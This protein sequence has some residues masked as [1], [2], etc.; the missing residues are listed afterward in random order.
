MEWYPILRFLHIA[1]A[2]VF[3][4]GLF[5]RQI[6]RAVA[7]KS[8]DVR[9]FAALSRGASRIE[10]LM[11]RP[12]SLA[13]ILF[14]IIVA[15][16]RGTPIFGFLQGASENWLLVAN[17]LLLGGILAVPLVFLP[18]GK[19]FDRYLVDALAGGQMTPEL[20]AAL[21]DPVVRLAHLYELVSAAIVVL[22][23]AL[24]PF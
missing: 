7:N 5:G 22:L 4:G 15:I 18:R 3:V 24:R 12:G 11:V 16:V 13:V 23:M 20:R 9:D 1:S 2:I 21:E 10:M 8:D 14:G 6:V 19:Q 17:L